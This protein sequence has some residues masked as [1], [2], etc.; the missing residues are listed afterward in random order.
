[1]SHRE[2]L[3]SS[4]IMGGS[5]VVNVAVGIVKTKIVAVILG[6]A[7]LGIIIL[8]QNVMQTA[9]SVASLGLGQA[10]TRQVAEANEEGNTN[11]IALVRRTLIVAT[12]T[13]G[14]IAAAVLWLAGDQLTAWFEL[15]PQVASQMRWLAIGTALTVA[16]QAQIALLMGFRRIGD[17]ARVSTLS[18]IVS[19]VIGLTA[20][21]LWGRGGIAAYVLSQVGAT[22]VIGHFYVMRLKRSPKVLLSPGAVMHQF[23]T[24][25]FFG[26]ALTVAAVTVNVGQLLARTL[27][28]QQL[29]AAAVGL[30]QAAWLVSVSY[31]GFVLQAMGADFY[32]RIVAAANEP[33]RLARLVND[34]IEVA[35]LLAAPVLLGML[36]TAPWLMQLLYSRAFEPAVQVLQWQVLGDVLK[37]ASWPI[38]YLLLAVNA[39][40]A[41]MVAEISAILVFLVAL[42][43]LLPIWGVQA[44]GAAVLA[45]YVFYFAFVFGVAA[46]RVRFRPTRG[47][48]VLL[49]SLFAACLL[50]FFI[51]RWMPL[52][53]AA[54]GI[55]LAA[56]AGGGC[57][58]HLRHAAR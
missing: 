16:T 11:A 51:A 18:V 44:S 22:F 7:G 26:A 8:L 48:L 54:L 6:P 10:G 43:L 38:G 30:F 14:F 5:A 20:V 4:S 25:L 9:A 13:L 50:M 49:G 52:A 53:G 35:L 2:I 47:N 45:M 56:G 12:A 17:L 34:Q 3:R 1:M 23:T 21:W 32:P 39:S 57:F 15:G 24:M 36:G 27:I 29:G 46:R 28:Q 31:L 42:R 55:V 19:A 41:Y 40:R 33:Q 37:V 58:W